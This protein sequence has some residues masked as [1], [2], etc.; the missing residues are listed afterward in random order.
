MRRNSEKGISSEN[1]FESL[2]E[3]LDLK[4]L[5]ARSNK[6]AFILNICS[7]PTKVKEAVAFI[8]RQ[9]EIVVQGSS[10]HPRVHLWGCLLESGVPLSGSPTHLWNHVSWGT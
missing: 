4:G 10:A 8:P 1:T 6:K 2:K 5:K 7:A 9:K 3:S